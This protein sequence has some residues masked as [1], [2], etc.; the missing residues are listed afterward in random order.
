MPPTN[1]GRD[2]G[3]DEYR[4]LIMETLE[5]LQRGITAID[6]KVD[7]LRTQEVEALKIDVAMLKVRASIYGALAGSLGGAIM[8][9]LITKA[10]G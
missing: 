2:G 10:L 4:H 8:G 5:R 7:S 1:R 3:F 9:V 6:V